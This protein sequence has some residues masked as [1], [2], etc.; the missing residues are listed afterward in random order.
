MRVWFQAGA[1]LLLSGALAS[2]GA[3]P[4]VPPA[5]SGA[6][7]PAPSVQPPVSKPT[8]K[9]VA[10]PAPPIPEP[11]PTPPASK[12]PTPAAAKP[13]APTPAPPK[14]QPTVK[15]PSAK[16]PASAPIDLPIYRPEKPVTS[17]PQSAD[18]ATCTHITRAEFD[19][20]LTDAKAKSGSK[21][22]DFRIVT[23]ITHDPESAVDFF[24][25]AGH[26][27]F[28][29][30]I[31]RSVDIAQDS[32]VIHTEGYSAGS[33]ADCAAW[34]KQFTKQDSKIKARAAAA[35]P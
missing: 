24:T 8:T 7:V 35:T 10:L 33:D 1:I 3:A 31:R 18:S 16:P 25:R 12:P 5:P 15:P 14:P 30:Y 4:A 6:A 21:A 23:R 29:A 13:A 32:I 20:M 34:I 11:K 22:T 2:A 28:P 9:P 17:D 26:R 19:K 27:A